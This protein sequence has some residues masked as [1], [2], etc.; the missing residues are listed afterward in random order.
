M[1]SSKLDNLL[2]IEQKVYSSRSMLGRHKQYFESKEA[3]SPEN[4]EV[5]CVFIYD[6]VARTGI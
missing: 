4:T 5:A 2:N 3:L 1:S 6:I